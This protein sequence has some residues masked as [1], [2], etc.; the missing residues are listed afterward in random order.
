[1]DTI[2]VFIIVIIVAPAIDVDGI[3]ESVS[4]SLIYGNN[5][6]SES[7]ILTLQAIGLHFYS[8]WNVASIDEWLYNRESSQLIVCPF[9]IGVCCYIGREWEISFRL[10][11]R[12]WIAVVYSSLV[13]VASVV[14]LR[15][16]IGQD[17]FST[18][19]PLS[20][21]FGYVQIYDCV[22]RGA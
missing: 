7:V 14:F 1:M 13:A 2:I 18:G 11:M 3:R 16:L 20:R 8:I 12:P 17:L 5:I 4:G 10:G 15:Y 22:S 19:M 21:Y 6:I 9:L